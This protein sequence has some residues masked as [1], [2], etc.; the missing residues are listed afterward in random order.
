[1]DQAASLLAQGQVVAFP[2]ETVYGLGANALD[3]GAV[4]AIFKAKGRPQD[5][6]LIVHL[7]EQSQADKYVQAIP[8][9]ACL[10]M[11]RFWPGP[12]TLVL[13]KTGQVPPVV[14]AG[15]DTV[16]LRVPD[17]PLALELLR[18]TGF[19]LAAPSANLSGRPSPTRA[20]HV[21]ADLGGRI[22][23][24]LD[25][26][27]TGWGLESTVLDCTVEPF[28]LLRPGGVTLEDL[29]ALVPV[30]FAASEGEDK[31]P[32]RSPGMK[33]QH[34]APDATVFLLTG[35]GV[36]AR[37][38]EESEPYRRRGQKVGV[39]TWNERSHLYSGFTVL[40]MGSEGDLQTLANKLYHLLRQADHLGL[41]VLYIEGVPEADLG[42]AIM[43][44]LR[45]AAD[46][47]E[48]K[49]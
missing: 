24:I 36:R 18:Q 23:A 7:G 19:P 13:A 27:E 30:T 25:G 20:E 17:H 21:L 12:L 15:L 3:S 43:N 28:R 6:P 46:Y 33:Y 9:K 34:Y 1:V 44:R 11:E 38:Q 22:P 35:Q 39:M 10:L 41:D 45:K 2:T 48:I 5:N 16:A 31:E 14:T 40:P 47:R 37:I 29:R 49:T 4:E 26:G 42:L 8:P 32:P